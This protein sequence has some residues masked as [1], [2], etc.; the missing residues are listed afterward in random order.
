M[1]EKDKIMNLSDL[2][3]IKFLQEF[4]DI[5]SD[6]MNVATIIVDNNG[7]ITKP[8]N[9]TEF[10]NKYIRGTELGAKR[11]LDCE[12]EG[13]KLAV[14]K[15][16]PVVYTCHAGLTH[17]VVPIIVSGQHLGA[18]IGSQIS[19][20]KLNEEHFIEVAKD[21]GINDSAY[22][23]ALSQIK[24]IPKE[25]ITAAAQLLFIVANAISEKALK[26]LELLE[27]NKRET[28]HRT[29]VETIRAS[30]DIDETKNR[31]VNLIGKTLNADRCLIMEYDK[32]NDKSLIVENEYLS[33]GDIMSYK[34]VNLY[35][36]APHFVELIK[37]GENI[38]VNNK[39]IQTAVD[40]EKFDMEREIL[41]KYKVTSAFVF[42]LYYFDELIGCLSISYVKE[43]HILSEDETNFINTVVGQIAT[44]IHHAQLYKTT[45]VQIERE[46]ISKNIIEILRNTID[47]STIKH[48][49][50]KNIGKYFNADRVFFSDFDSETNRYLP[51]DRDSEY[52]S[53]NNV[54]SFI[55]YDFS[56]DCIQEHIKPLIEKRELIIYNWEE[57]IQKKPKS[58][59]FMDFFEWA[60]IKSSYNIPVLREQKLLGCFC[61]EFTQKICKLS[62]EDIN[63]IRN[64]CTQAG[65]AIYHAELYQKAQE[66]AQSKS[67]FIA[68]MSH[69]LK[70]PLNVI[71][72]FAE[73]LAQSE[74]YHD[75]LINY[76]E[77]VN[78]S[79]GQVLALTNFIISI[80]KQGPENLD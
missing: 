46:K 14:E 40:S 48:Q 69:D 61:I 32:D 42:P 27:K 1:A 49:F 68:R 31:I 8:S 77:S 79:A 52:L 13:M 35:E 7:T 29:I 20:N 30:L 51:I 5:F 73:I 76:L 9:F 71:T 18:I 38:I 23:E 72:G 56:N 44:A 62:D 78:N 43:N 17:F 19:A 65:I 37:K 33:S 24:I 12:I 10:C 67:E 47:K 70:M 55:D 36:V 39:K 74:L 80:S 57:Y 26:N 58:K 21:L 4:Q 75:K 59:E 45:K 64:M 66:L 34:G 50:V 53:S 3:D 15:G 25:N 41:D 6:A 11:C 16:G 63:S 22:M 60:N 54:R 2:I 28:L